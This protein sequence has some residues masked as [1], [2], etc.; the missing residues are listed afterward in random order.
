MEDWKNYG[1]DEAT[2]RRHL[3]RYTTT[4]RNNLESFEMKKISLPEPGSVKVNKHSK[5]HDSITSSP[6]SDMSSSN[7]FR[8]GHP[9][10]SFIGKNFL[11]HRL[12]LE[13]LEDRPFSNGYLVGTE[14]FSLECNELPKLGRKRSSNLYNRLEK[15]SKKERTASG[16]ELEIGTNYANMGKF[17][18]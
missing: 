8:V 18:N 9:E 14:E 5:D 10:G 7:T 3:P 17:D 4:E 11:S 2:D 6:F 16:D 15:S 1:P 12:R 13:A